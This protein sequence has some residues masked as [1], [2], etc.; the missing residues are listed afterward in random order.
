MVLRWLKLNFTTTGRDLRQ[1]SIEAEANCVVGQVL[2]IA[3]DKTIVASQGKL[4]KQQQHQHQDQ[5]QQQQW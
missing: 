1:W 4:A 2:S 5:Q 3:T